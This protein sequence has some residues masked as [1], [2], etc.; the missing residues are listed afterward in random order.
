MAFTGPSVATITISHSGRTRETIVST[1]IVRQAS[2][3]TVCIN[4][5]GKSPLQQ[6]CGVFLFTAAQETKY[7]MEA[8]FSRI[9]QMVV[10]DVLYQRLATER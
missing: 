8:L 6:Y 7:R 3:K 1:P 9:A 10:I 5:Y 2:A 4:N